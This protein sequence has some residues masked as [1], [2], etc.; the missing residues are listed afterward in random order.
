MYN[1][2]SRMR[3]IGSYLDSMGSSSTGKSKYLEPLRKLL[4]GFSHETFIFFDTET[5]GLDHHTHQVT[6]IAAVAVQGADFKEID[7]MYGRAVLSDATLK[8]IEKQREGKDLPKDKRHLTVEQVLEM[9][10]Y[11]ESTV[12]AR[13]ELDILNEF[14]DFC[15]KHDGLIVGHNAEFDLRMVGTK[16]GKVPTRGVWDTMLFSKFFFHPML[17]ALEETGDETAKKIIL[18]MRGTNGRMHSTLGKVLEALGEPVEG[19][20]TAMADV[21][22]TVKVFRGILRYVREHLDVAD[23]ESYGKYQAKAF[24]VVRDFKRG[25]GDKGDNPGKL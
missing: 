25:I 15:K 21:R 11:H 19:W 4:D 6:E 13:P 24:R 14:K 9:N 1:I 17:L 2:S 10:K 22:S 7:S 23:T 8:Q 20:H 16:V 3:I 12:E 5:T 18:S